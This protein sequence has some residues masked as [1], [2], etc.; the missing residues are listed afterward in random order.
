MHAYIE[1]ERCIAWFL[2][3][4]N[5][6]VEIHTA[7]PIAPQL[8]GLKELLN[9]ADE[10]VIVDTGSSSRRDAAIVLDLLGY[11]GAV[12]TFVVHAST[13]ERNGEYEPVFGAYNPASS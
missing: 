6:S 10:V 1:E 5:V 4:P 11:G 3:D 7:Q 8:L 9:Q 2:G 13:P 12:T